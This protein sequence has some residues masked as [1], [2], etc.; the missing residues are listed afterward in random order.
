MKNP[1]IT[2]TYSATQLQ[3]KG[4][5]T[6]SSLATEDWIVSKALFMN[7]VTPDIGVQLK[8]MTTALSGYNYIYKTAAGTYT[9]SFAVSNTTKYDSKS[10]AKEI[11]LTVTP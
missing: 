2:W 5:N 3:V 7:R 4:T 9:A 6:T 1:A 8:N 10:G 11:V